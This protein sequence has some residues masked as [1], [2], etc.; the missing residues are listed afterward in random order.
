MEKGDENKT[1]S[2]TAT[3]MTRLSRQRATRNDAIKNHSYTRAGP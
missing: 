1:K 3:H 2:A